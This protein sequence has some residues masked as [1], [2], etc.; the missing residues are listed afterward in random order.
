MEAKSVIQFKASKKNTS[1]EDTP[2]FH[3]GDYTDAE[4]NK[5]AKRLAN[6]LRTTIRWNYTGSLQGHYTLPEII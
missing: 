2:A 5:L 1:W 6:A 4:A 3:A